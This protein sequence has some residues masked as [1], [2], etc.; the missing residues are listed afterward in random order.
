MKT[1]FWMS[2]EAETE[3]RLSGLSVAIQTAISMLD[4]SKMRAADCL[5]AASFYNED[6]INILSQDGVVALKGDPTNKGALL[7]VQEALFRSELER[8]YPFTADEWELERDYAKQMPG[9]VPS[10]SSFEV[11]MARWFGRDWQ[12]QIIRGKAQKSTV[13][14]E[15]TGEMK[16]TLT[17]SGKVKEKAEFKTFSVNVGQLSCV[18]T[19]PIEVG[20]CKVDELGQADHLPVIGSNGKVDCTCGKNVADIYIAPVLAWVKGTNALSGNAA[21][22]AQSQS[23]SAG[24]GDMASGAAGGRTWEFK[25]TGIT[26]TLIYRKC[27]QPFPEV[28]EWKSATWEQVMKFLFP[29]VDAATKSLWRQS[30]YIPMD[31]IDSDDFRI[32]MAECFRD[33]P[34]AMLI[35]KASRLGCT[36]DGT[37]RIIPSKEAYQLSLNAFAGMNAPRTKGGAAKKVWIKEWDAAKYGKSCLDLS[38]LKGLDARMEELL[39]E[40]WDKKEAAEENG[41]DVDAELVALLDEYKATEKERLDFFKACRGKMRAQ[42]VAKY[43]KSGELKRVDE[44]GRFSTRV[45]GRG[46]DDKRRTGDKSTRVN[47]MRIDVLTLPVLQLRIDLGLEAAGLVGTDES[48][49]E[50]FASMG[51]EVDA[52]GFKQGKLAA[53]LAEAGFVAVNKG[54]KLRFNRAVGPDE[55]RSVLELVGM[56]WEMFR[57]EGIKAG[58]FV[59]TKDEM[60]DTDW[61]GLMSKDIEADHFN[62]G[63]SKKD[64]MERCVV[65]YMLRLSK[66]STEA[67]L[68]KI[69]ARDQTVYDESELL[70][71]KTVPKKYL[72]GELAG[73]IASIAIQTVD[74]DQLQ[75]LEEAA[76]LLEELGE[77]VTPKMLLKAYQNPARYERRLQAKRGT[78]EDKFALLEAIWNA[79]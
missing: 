18:S 65:E 14:K 70:P 56:D 46:K 42:N 48:I 50:H 58:R 4:F 69:M 60:D 25:V 38:V 78:M 71:V 20:S 1:M 9:Y 73:V 19:K 36:E 76:E 51:Y 31:E 6:C 3:L 34:L 43:D 75:K 66:L 47:G 40:Y 64:N 72:T 23:K 37:G 13:I 17:K 2:N 28:E 52:D 57:S 27:G 49:A 68:L 33:N 39:D 61:N 79:K 10:R 11:F 44:K 41:E 67:S 53:K 16:Q 45:H 12:D 8:R 54:N 7:F 59:P 24:T 21:E 62:P 32:V 26:E 22:D 35:A 77:E 5:E 30:W 63:Q 15:Y 55:F 29:K 74:G